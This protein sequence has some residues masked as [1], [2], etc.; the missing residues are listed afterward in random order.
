M[1]DFREFR[2]LDS[3]NNIS[4]WAFIIVVVTIYATLLWRHLLFHIVI[5]HQLGE[6][7]AI[8]LGL[9]NTLWHVRA[10][11]LQILANN[12]IILLQILGLV[13]IDLN[14]MITLILASWDQLRINIHF[15]T[16]VWC[17]CRATLVFRIL[18]EPTGHV[19]IGLARIH[20]LSINIIDAILRR[21]LAKLCVR[22][23]VLSH[24]ICGKLD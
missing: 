20:R 9:L 3:L 22:D 14:R 7:A 21:L 1:I 2:R 12:D 19:Y 5:L 15:V 18:G 16:I 17:G 13:S 8:H 10:L 24:L 23:L 4:N 11:C 6:T